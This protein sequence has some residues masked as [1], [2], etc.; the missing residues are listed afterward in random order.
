MPFVNVSVKTQKQ[1]FDAG[2]VGGNWKFWVT[3]GVG[4][5]IEGPQQTPNESVIFFINDDVSR[6]QI[7]TAYAIRLDG[8]G[9]DLGP[10]ASVPFTVE[11]FTGVLI[12]VAGGVS[13]RPPSPEITPL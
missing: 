13:T 1:A 4:D 9:A 5:V 6:D 10:E 2:T 8:D 7:F 12:D 3:D 11:G